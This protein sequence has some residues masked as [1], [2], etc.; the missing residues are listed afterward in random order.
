[1]ETDV[2]FATAERVRTAEREGGDDVR[3]SEI[4]VLMW[5]FLAKRRKTAPIANDCLAEAEKVLRAAHY[6]RA[7]SG[8]EKEKKASELFLMEHRRDFRKK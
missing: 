4:E 6:L 1:M 7:D 5:K 3:R 2:L 8:K